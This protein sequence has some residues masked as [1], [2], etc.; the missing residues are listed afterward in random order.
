[1]DVSNVV[2]RGV[3]RVR[4]EGWRQREKSCRRE[5]RRLVQKSPHRVS[6]EPATAGRR[7]QVLLLFLDRTGTIRRRYQIDRGFLLVVRSPQN[8]R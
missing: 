6:L 5:P 4:P 3:R 1:M 8:A 2:V 7:H